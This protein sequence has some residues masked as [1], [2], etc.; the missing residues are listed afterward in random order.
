[1]RRLPLLTLLVIPLLAVAAPVPKETPADKMKRLFGEVADAK[2][3]YDFTLDGDKL[4]VTMA[5]NASHNLAEKTLPRVEQEVKGDFEMKV[6]LTF[7][8]PKGKGADAVSGVVAAGL[9]VW[10]EDG[11]NMVFA[12]SYW[13]LSTGKNV[14]EWL[15]GN[16]VRDHT[17][18]LAKDW[19]YTHDPR[20]DVR[21]FTSHNLRL[22]RS[23]GE[24]TITDSED[25]KEWGVARIYK[26][27]LPDT[28]RV[29]VFGLNT[30]NAE[31]TATFSDFTVTPLK[32][33]K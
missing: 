21:A 2:K 29:G 5:S 1:L 9:S 27:T 17:P 6:V 13:P 3:G 12:P 16:F 31:C 23:G 19:S 26:L 18:K 28:I 25:G 20:K 8:P 4:V 11:R 7:A 30:T 22:V 10:V 24:L 33:A 15:C 14:V 32:P